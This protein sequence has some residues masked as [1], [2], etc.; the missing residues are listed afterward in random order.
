MVQNIKEM[1]FTDFTEAFPAFLVMVMIPFTYSIVD[2]MAFGFIAYPIAKLAAGRGREVKVV[3]Y[4]IT[5]L[6]L[7]NFILHALM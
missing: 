5:V 6:F 2:G 7:A 3:M 4:V 1:N